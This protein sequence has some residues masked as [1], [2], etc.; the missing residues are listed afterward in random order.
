ME[1]VGLLRESWRRQCLCIDNIAS[2]MTQ[3]LLHSKPSTDGWDLAYHLCHIH[4]TRMYWLEMASGQKEWPGIGYLIDYYV[5]PQ[6]HSYDLDKIR[7]QL[8]ASEAAVSDWLATSLS[9]EGA[10]GPYDHPVFYLQHMVWHE[11]WHAGL[12]MLRFQQG[13]KRR[14]SKFGGAHQ[15][16]F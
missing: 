6:T 3:E 14:H 13:T 4:D 7:S 8:K 5:D 10:A 11:G 16:K 9:Q 1:L 12:L 15:H 2:L